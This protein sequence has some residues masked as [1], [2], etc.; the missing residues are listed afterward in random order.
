MR[1]WIAAS[2]SVVVLAVVVYLGFKQYQQLITPGELAKLNFDTYWGPGEVDKHKNN[3]LTMLHELHYAQEP[4][5]KLRRILSSDLNLPPPL[6][7][8]NFEYGV[9]TEWLK[10]FVKYWRDDYLERW[11]VRELEFN[12]VPHYTTYIQG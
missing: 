9:N 8:V 11:I 10:E 4:I 2:V 1:K 5:D 7:G 6:E 3:N 12:R